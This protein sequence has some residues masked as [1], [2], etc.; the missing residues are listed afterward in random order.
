MIVDESLTMTNDMTSDPVI[1]ALDFDSAGAAD[2]LVAS[3]G[4]SA[5]FYKVGMEL[6]AAAG[7]DY[8]RGLVDRG[9]RV[10]V[11]ARSGAEFPTFNLLKTSYERG[12]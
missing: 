12:E 4:D 9:K 5:S 11:A 6:Y 7:M 8:V 1:V 3:P 2:N 10:S